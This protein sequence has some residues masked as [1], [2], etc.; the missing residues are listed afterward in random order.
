MKEMTAEQIYEQHIKQ[1][2]A[3]EQQRLLEIMHCQIA[4]TT[5]DDKPTGKSRPSIMELHGLGAEIWGE[6]DAQE[7]V[8]AL[9]DEWNHRP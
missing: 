7:Y 9:R 4:Q 3:A 8:N 2:P 1:M 5:L 6:V